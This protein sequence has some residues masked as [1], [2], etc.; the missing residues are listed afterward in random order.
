MKPVLAGLSLMTC[1]MGC[2]RSGANADSSAVRTD[3]A[4]ATVGVGTSTGV[5]PGSAN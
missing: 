3:T 5:T 2:S 4:K 1:V